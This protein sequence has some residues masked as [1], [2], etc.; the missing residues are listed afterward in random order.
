[1]ETWNAH[2]ICPQKKRANHVAG[3]PNE[4]YTNQS[5]PYYR[6]TPNMELLLQL[7]ETVKDVGK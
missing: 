6:W 7:E 1:M 3:I 5:L 2:R 4:L